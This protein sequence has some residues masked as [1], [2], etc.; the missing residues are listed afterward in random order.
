M[1]TPA[2]FDCA[3]LARLAGAELLCGVAAVAGTR[4]TPLYDS[5]TALL[6]GAQ[7]IVVLGAEVFAE[8]VDLVVPEKAMGEAAARDLY[9][10]HLD[11]LNGRLNRGLYALAYALRDAGE[12]VLP[13][14]SLG[15]PQDARYLRG[16]L[17]F[18]HAA[19]YAGL[20]QLGRSSLLVTPQFGPRLRLACL[21]TTAAIAPS[22]RLAENPCTACGTC[23][24]RCPAGALAE[25]APGQPYAIDR[26]ACAA[27]RGGAGACATCMACCPVGRS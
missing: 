23:I 14:P 1:Q 13:L 25:P 16:I 20:G 12:R 2:T 9:T 15:T 7:S 21:L 5:A 19:V 18:K 22:P 17:S 3:G 6:P 4:G 26:F 10:P 11:W 24:E 27:Y 8:V